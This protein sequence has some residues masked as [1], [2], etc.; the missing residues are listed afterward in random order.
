[1]IANPFITSK[2]EILSALRGE[3][4][5]PIQ[6]QFKANKAN[7]KANL[8][9]N[10]PNSNPILIKNKCKLLCYQGNIKSKQKALERN[11]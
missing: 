3:K 5:N 2:Y 8:S 11:D 9:Q 1:M 6:T 7:N 10:K 4:T